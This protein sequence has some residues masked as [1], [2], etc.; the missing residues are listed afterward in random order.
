MGLFDN[1]G[2]ILNIAGPVGGLI[3]YII[4]GIAVICIMEGVAEMIGHW[5]IANAMVEF[6]K[7]FVDK[8]L[9]IVVGLA[10][11]Y[12]SPPPTYLQTLTKL[13]THMPSVLPPLSLLQQ[14]WL[15]IGTG[16]WYCRTSCLFLV[17][18]YFYSW[19]TA[20]EYL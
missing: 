7:A 20:W 14:I 16:R 3:A 9:A 8:D 1:S 17:C 18:L 4:V 15:V 5:P 19:S 2:E 10:Y 13:G 6:V 12:P 11:W